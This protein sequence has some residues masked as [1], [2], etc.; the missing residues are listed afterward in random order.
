ALLGPSHV[1]RQATRNIK[2]DNNTRWDLG[3]STGNSAPGCQLTLAAG[4]NIQ[5]GDG[6]R[7]IASSGW[8]VT[9]DAGVDFTSPTH[10]VRPGVGGIYLNGGPGLSYNGS[11]DSFG[12]NLTLHAGLEV[13]LKDGDTHADTVGLLWSDLGPAIRSAATTPLH[14]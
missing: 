2:L 3:Q 6:S 5:F 14:P 8:S 4:N 10:L 9:L 7:I 1:D 13:I 12:G 11:I